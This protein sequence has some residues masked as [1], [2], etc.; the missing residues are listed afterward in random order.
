MCPRKSMGVGFA[1]FKHV[2]LNTFLNITWIPFSED[3][4]PL[5]SHVDRPAYHTA[6][7]SSS[8]YRFKK[9][10]S[11]RCFFFFFRIYICYMLHV[12]KYKDT[13]GVMP[14]GEAGQWGP[15]LSHCG[16]WHWTVTADLSPVWFRV[17]LRWS[18]GQLD[19]LSYVSIW[20]LPLGRCPVAMILILLLVI[21]GDFCL[22][23]G[24]GLVLVVVLYGLGLPSCFLS[25]YYMDWDRLLLSILSTILVWDCLLVS[26]LITIWVWDCLPYRVLYWFRTGSVSSRECPTTVFKKLQSRRE[27]LSFTKSIP[28]L[29]QN[30]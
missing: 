29:L 18:H 28:M 21:N 15:R 7:H 1:L 5:T 11:V 13:C 16:C 2:Y 22:W 4:A 6:M 20:G 3:A 12:C 8:P 9:V 27:A 26:F 17:V 23:Y 10:D 30:W 19:W 25:C 24:L 14:P